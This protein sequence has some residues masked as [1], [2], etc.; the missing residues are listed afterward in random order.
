[1][2]DVVARSAPRVGARHHP[3]VCRRADR[4]HHP[5]ASDGTAELTVRP[6]AA[7]FS[8]NLSLRSRADDVLMEI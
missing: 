2:A 4:R 5:L 6:S 7:S 8:R 3:V 1:M